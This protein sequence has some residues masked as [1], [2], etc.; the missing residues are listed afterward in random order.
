MR[1]N[2]NYS[3]DLVNLMNQAQQSQDNAA[4]QLSTG[5]R[6]NQP[7]DDPAAAAAM[8]NENSRS[9]TIDQY[10]ANSD[11]V[12]N[13][14]NTADSTLS[15][16]TTMLQRAVSLGVEG[17][18]GTMNQTD[19]NSI[20]TEVTGIQTQMLALANTSY[21]GQYLFAGTATGSAPY[22]ADPT[23]PGQIDYV[24]NSQQNKVQIGTGLSVATNLPGSSIFSQ[25]DA[26][27]FDALQSLVTALQ[28]GN[29]SSIATAETSVNTSLGAVSTAQVFYGGAVDELNNNETYLSQEKLNITTYQN[30]LVSADT[31]TAATNES[32]AESTLT[33]TVAAAAQIDQQVN[34]LTYLH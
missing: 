24:G 27:V 11:S 20:A 12:T 15:S 32:E 1:V 6:V 3:A 28:S 8:V 30:T 14:L 34:L 26:N 5:R 10:T 13:V 23:N 18:N 22:V 16:A 17:A 25:P 29:S 31:A 7:S 2:P 21:A 4:E 9:A 19:L 33:A